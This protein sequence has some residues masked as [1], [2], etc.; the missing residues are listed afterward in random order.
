MNTGLSLEELTSIAK[1]LIAAFLAKYGIKPSVDG[2]EVH[3]C[4]PHTIWTQ[5]ARIPDNLIDC[6]DAE[7]IQQD[8]VKYLILYNRVLTGV[9]FGAYSVALYRCPCGCGDFMFVSIYR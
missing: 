5:Q 3:V 4:P 1:N 9:K 7:I 8:L 2:M 6:F